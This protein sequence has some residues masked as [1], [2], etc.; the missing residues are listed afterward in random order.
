MK[1]SKLKLDKKF[2][3]YIDL[4]DFSGFK[5]ISAQN[6]YDAKYKILEIFDNFK[7]KIHN[8]EVELYDDN[9]DPVAHT[10]ELYFIEYL[11]KDEINKFIIVM[12]DGVTSIEDKLYSYVG[13]DLLCIIDINK[14]ENE[15]FN[16]YPKYYLIKYSYKDNYG[17]LYYDSILINAIDRNHME[18]ILFYGFEDIRQDIDEIE[19]IDII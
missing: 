19:S 3:V 11:S 5:T 4:E 1:T 16:G 13:D 8:I 14:L 15:E 18:D 7:I 9:D 10:N 2:R 12:C 17:S 6:V